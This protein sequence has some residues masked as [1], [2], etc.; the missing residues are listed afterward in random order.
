LTENAKSPAKATSGSCGWDL[1]ASYDVIVPAYGSALVLTD[2]S[3]KMPAGVYARVAP[4]S[5]IALM[6]NINVGAG[7]IGNTKQMF[8][9][10]LSLFLYRSRL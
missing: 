7:V 6:Y 9:C 8:N 2:I 10:I 1:Y 3:I 5:G 4:R